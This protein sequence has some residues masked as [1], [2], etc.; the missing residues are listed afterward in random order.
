MPVSRRTTLQAGSAALAGAILRPRAQ[1]EEKTDVLILGAGIAGLH[2]ARMLDAQ[3]LNVTVLE[4][5]GRVGGRCWTARDLPGRPDFGAVQIGP[6]YGR[7]RGNATDL[8]I[9]LVE[10][11]KDSMSETQLPPVAVSLDGAPPTADW[12]NASMNHLAP[13]ERSLQPLQ[14]LSHYLFKNNPLVDLDDWQ[15]PAFRSIDRMTLRQ[16]LARNGASP[17][18]LRLIDVTIPATSLDDANALDFLRK[19]YYYFWESKNGATSIV[20]DGTDA[21]TTAMANSLRRPVALNKIVAG[22][23]AGSQSVT[24]TC[25]D[26]S[27]YTAR[28][29]ISTI[30]LSVMKD[31]P[32]V[33]NVPREQHAGW[34]RQRYNQTIQIYFKFKAPFWEKDGLPATMW[35]NGPA[36]L[37]LKV[38]SLTSASGVLYSYINGRATDPL[39]RI[40]AKAIGDRALAELVRLRPA[41]KNQVEV[42]HVH[43]WATYPFSKGHIAYFAPGDIA[44]YADIVGRPVGALH[45]AGE[46]LCRMHAGL[47][48]AC[49]TAEIAAI[50]IL[51]MLGKA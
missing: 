46:H 25:R 48:G 31:I 49:E 26:G 19:N 29:C 30:P 20:R 15:K 7:V 36:E 45:F 2:A 8:D 6:G 24:V 22:I 33:G 23:D 40:S 37:F 10:P 44:R 5:S 32:I 47:E 1:S 34:N 16:Y 42:A 41:A 18:A 38:P 50:A 4:G 43:N 17:E 9:E 21:L 27:T 13:G 12:T 3:G 14:L 39:M 51:N 28:G 35:T 11:P